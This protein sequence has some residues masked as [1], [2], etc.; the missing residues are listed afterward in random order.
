ML[1]SAIV[2]R[3]LFYT[4]S[5]LSTEE[6]LKTPQTVVPDPISMGFSG[7]SGILSARMFVTLS[8]MKNICQPQ[9]AQSSQKEF[10]SMTCSPWTVSDEPLLGQSESSVSIRIF[11]ALRKNARQEPSHTQRQ[12]RQENAEP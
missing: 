12:L 5:G 8:L 1:Q 3:Q 9:R 6:N 11:R 4:W 10:C 2:H 7:K